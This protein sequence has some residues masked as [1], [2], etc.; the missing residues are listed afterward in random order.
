VHHSFSIQNKT[1]RKGSEI[2]FVSKQNTGICSA[3]FALKQNS[4]FHMPN[5]KE[6][7]QNKANEAN[8]GKCNKTIER[9]EKTKQK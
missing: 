5:K 4:S 6:M 1:K 8:K 7:K 9:S 3:C 2:F